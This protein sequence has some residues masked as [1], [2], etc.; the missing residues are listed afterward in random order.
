MD[1][2]PADRGSPLREAPASSAL[3]QWRW[4][5]LTNRQVFSGRPP[6]DKLSHHLRIGKTL[7]V[8]IYVQEWPMRSVAV[9]STP[10]LHG[11]KTDPSKRDNGAEPRNFGCAT[12]LAMQEGSKELGRQC[13][14][15]IGMKAA[16]C[17]TGRRDDDDVDRGADSFSASEMW[18]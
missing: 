15:G 7:H 10:C 11:P 18:N 3:E 6:S 4:P 1:R 12:G 16:E 5:A 2:D 14:R 9:A 13:R 17:G 8:Q